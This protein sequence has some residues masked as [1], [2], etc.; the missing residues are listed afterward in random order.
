MKKLFL[1][2][3]LVVLL[4]A[5]FPATALSAS[6][7]EI[8]VHVRNQTGGLVNLSLT[9]PGGSPLFKTLEEGVTSFTITEGTYDFYASMPCGNQAGQWNINVNKTLYLT[10]NTGAPTITIIKEFKGCD[11][12]IYESYFGESFFSWKIWEADLIYSTYYNFGVDVET[13]KETVDAWNTH[14]TG[15]YSSGCYDGVTYYRLP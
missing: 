3:L 1:A 5:P 4:V 9:L 12:G 10:C 15:D 6:P 11:M 2:I 8:T 7:A 13:M 14:G